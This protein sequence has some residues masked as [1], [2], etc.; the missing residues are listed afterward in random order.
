MTVRNSERCRTER[1]ARAGRSFRETT[2]GRT[3]GA[4]G[5]GVLSDGRAR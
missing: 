3:G 5:N 1:K 2:R 4:E